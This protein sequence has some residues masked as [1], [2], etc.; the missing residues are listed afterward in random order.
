MTKLKT[1]ARSK[2]H[3]VQN[4]LVLLQVSWMAI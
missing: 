1:D 3:H 4:A 2:A